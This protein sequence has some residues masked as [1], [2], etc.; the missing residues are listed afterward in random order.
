MKIL[1]NIALPFY[2]KTQLMSRAI[3]QLVATLNDG[4][5]SKLTIA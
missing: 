3:L 5:S 2:L 4:P 1:I